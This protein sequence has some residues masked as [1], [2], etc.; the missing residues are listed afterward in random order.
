MRIDCIKSD[1]AH[2]A[3]QGAVSVLIQSNI[4]VYNKINMILYQFFGT[5]A[6]A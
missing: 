6:R 2:M 3:K 1:T 5:H 4:L